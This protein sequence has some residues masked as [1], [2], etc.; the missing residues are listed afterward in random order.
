[1]PSLAEFLKKIERQRSGENAREFLENCGRYTVS[2]N[3]QIRQGL[4]QRDRKGEK[5]KWKSCT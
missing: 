3:S 4:K 5:V 2:Q 1:M